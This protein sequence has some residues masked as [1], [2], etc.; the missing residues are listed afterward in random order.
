MPVCILKRTCNIPQMITAKKA[1]KNLT[2]KKSKQGE[3]KKK[4]RKTNHF[5]LELD[6]ALCRAANEEGNGAG[7][8]GSGCG[9]FALKCL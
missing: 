6:F 9:W 1:E 3:D 4:T 8:G 2:K 7:G 5:P